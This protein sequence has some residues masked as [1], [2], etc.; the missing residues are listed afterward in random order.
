VAML[1]YWSPSATSAWLLFFSLVLLL[2]G[3][4]IRCRFVGRYYGLRT[5]WR[6]YARGAG[7]GAFSLLDS[8]TG[9]RTRGGGGSN[10]GGGT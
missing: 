4:E 8:S 10:P 3:R 9:G 2:R 1:P 7:S 6:A 5:S